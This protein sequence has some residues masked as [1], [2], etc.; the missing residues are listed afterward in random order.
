PDSTVVK[1]VYRHTLTA[2]EDLPIYHD[3]QGE[4]VGDTLETLVTVG[5]PRP[6]ELSLDDMQPGN[7]YPGITLHVGEMYYSP[8]YLNYTDGTQ[9]DVTA[10]AKIEYFNDGSVNIVGDVEFTAVRPG[11]LLIRVSLNDM[12]AAQTY[13]VTVIE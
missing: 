13:L 6:F 7:P 10:D 3:L 2:P 5:E 1:D 8:V 4:P 9:E 12:V 11:Q